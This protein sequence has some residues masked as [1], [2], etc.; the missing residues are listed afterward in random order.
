MLSSHDSVFIG[1]VIDT[2]KW[3]NS[4]KADSHKYKPMNHEKR[5][6]AIQQGKTVYSTSCSEIT[7]CSHGKKNSL[8]TVIC[9]NSMWPINLSKNTKV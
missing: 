7:R 5:E 6:K 2:H 8:S 4:L 3:K 9:I 1:E